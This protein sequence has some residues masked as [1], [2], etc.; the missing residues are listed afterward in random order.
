VLVLEDVMKVA[1]QIVWT[2]GALVLAVSTSL[3]ARAQGMGGFNI[4][5]VQIRQMVLGRFQEQIGFTDE[6]WKV[7]EP[8][9]W[10]VLALQVESGS[11]TLGGM[12]GN[13]RGLARGGAGRGGFNMNAIIAQVFNNGQPSVAIQKQQELQALIDDPGATPQ[14]FRVKLEEYRAAVRKVKEQ[15]LEAQTNLQGVLTLR[16]EATLM[17]MGFLD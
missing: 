15:L 11:G 13:A 3:P 9:L 10:R 16:Q 4:D 8:K 1:R 2:L 7:V 6:E 14:A 5:P 12:V 17:Q